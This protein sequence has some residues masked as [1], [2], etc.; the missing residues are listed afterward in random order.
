MGT[1]VTERQVMDLSFLMNHAA[2][3][4]NTRMNAAFAEIGMTPRAFCVLAHALAGDFTQIELAKLTDL[5]KTT[6][7]I[8]LD[9]LERVGYAERRPSPADRRARIVAVTPS[10][11]D[12]VAVGQQVADRVHREVLEALPA[13]QREVFV[14]AMTSLVGGILAEPVEA[15]EGDR[16]V[17]RA[18]S[19][20]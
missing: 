15:A 14:D 20:G 7:V 5:D 19:R 17:R 6:M 18:R 1:P 12:A 4:L 10:G 3:T 8:A 9:E 11:L 13:G 2:H 16:P